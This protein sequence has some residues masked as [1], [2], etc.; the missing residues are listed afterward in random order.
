MLTLSLNI[1]RTILP[2]FVRTSRAQSLDQTN[3]Q[4]GI[5]VW[6]LIWQPTSRA[7]RGTLHNLSLR[8]VT[9]VSLLIKF[10]NVHLW[11]LHSHSTIETL[12]KMRDQ[13]PPISLQHSAYF[14]V[15]GHIQIIHDYRTEKLLV[16]PQSRA[17]NTV[18]VKRIYSISTGTS[19]P[20]ATLMLT[21]SRNSFKGKRRS[22]SPEQTHPWETL[23]WVQCITHIKAPLLVVICPLPHQLSVFLRLQDLQ[24]IMQ[25]LR[26]QIISPDLILK[27]TSV[28]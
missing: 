12:S 2:S 10:L 1:T 4:C 16:Q 13:S 7:W 3:H 8:Y 11:S 22:S 28:S 21:S 27:L 23:R 9:S 25:G 15:E 5:L 6:P 17:R 26:A 14:L 24:C 20:V 19:N 18:I